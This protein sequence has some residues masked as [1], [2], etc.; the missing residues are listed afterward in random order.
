MNALLARI[1]RDK[2]GV[3]DQLNY[4]QFLPHTGEGSNRVI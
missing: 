3:M 2:M 1:H 4:P